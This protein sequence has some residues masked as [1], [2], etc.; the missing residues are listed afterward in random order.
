MNEKHKS[1]LHKGFIKQV[2]RQNKKPDEVEIRLPLAIKLP[3]RF[4]GEYIHSLTVSNNKWNEPK[5]PV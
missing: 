3:K 1:K 5:K 2:S 4:K